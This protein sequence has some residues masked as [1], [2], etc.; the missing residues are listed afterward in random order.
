MLALTAYSAV[1]N[2][3]IRPDN[4]IAIVGAGGLGLMAMQLSKAVFGA[5]IIAIDLKDDKLKVANE[6]GADDI[7]NSKK[8]DPVEKIMKLT[9]NKGVDVV[10]DFVN[11]SKTTESNM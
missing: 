10:I 3:E 1:K 11:N 2:A 6:N 9:N 5:R 8:E 4:N 7:I